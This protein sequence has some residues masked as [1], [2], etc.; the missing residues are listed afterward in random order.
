[1]WTFGNRSYTNDKWHIDGD[2]EPNAQ[3]NMA[4]DELELITMLF[5]VDWPWFSK[6][7]IMK[8]VE[9]GPYHHKRFWTF[10]YP[11][12]SDPASAGLRKKR[13]Y[14]MPRPEPP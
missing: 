11:A 6:L 13:C 3:E 8:H 7:P 12:D 14:S 10:P 2:A 9:E 4:V 1:M 5:L